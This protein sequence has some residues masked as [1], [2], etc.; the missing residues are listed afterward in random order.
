MQSRISWLILLWLLNLPGYASS[1]KLVSVSEVANNSA[2]IF[3]GRVSASRVVQ[4]PGS[5]AVHTLIT[6]EVLD[7]LKGEYDQSSIELS[8]LGGSV[9]EFTMHVT[10][11]HRPAPGER[12]IYFV[13]NPARSQVNPLYGW[14]QGHF[15]L[16]FQPGLGQMTVLTQTGKTVY[17]LENAPGD[18]G[19]ALSHGVARGVHTTAAAAERPLTP[20]EFKQ[21]IRGMLR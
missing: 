5:K 2:L 8:F 9:G 6:F 19:S 17:G 3:E 13:E 15:K 7:V 1:I 14:D 4:R 12:G 18:G 20:T 10:D 11:L 16:E 21:Q